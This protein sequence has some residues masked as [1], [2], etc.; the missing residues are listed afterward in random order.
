MA[1]NVIEKIAK[2]RRLATSTNV[3][4]AAAA[5]AAADRLMQEHGIAEAQL[6]A[7]G[8][9]PKENPVEDLSPLAFWQGKHT[10]SWQVQL[11][12]RLVSHYGCSCYL[13]RATREINPGQWAR[14]ATLCIIGRPSDIASVRY[15]YTWLTVEISRLASLNAGNGRA[16]INSFRLGAVSGVIEAMR[17][18]KAKVMADARAEAGVHTGNGEGAIVAANPN[19]SAALVLIDNRAA[20]ALKVRDALHGKMGKGRS[21]R[22][23]SDGGGYHEGRTAGARLGAQHSAGKLNAGGTRALKG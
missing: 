14:G 2:L 5:A 19:A 7:A 10:P 21:S 17:A 8:E 11:G 18:E 9:A 4:E 6:E 3:N 12:A 16:W 23:P 20:E 15:M 1:T 22:G 13:G